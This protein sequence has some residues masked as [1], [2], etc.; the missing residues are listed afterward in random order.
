MIPH[1]INYCWFG[2]E[3]LN[4][5]SKKCIESWKKYLPGWQ[6]KEW[7]EDNFD[8]NFNDYVKEA[9]ERKKW[10]FVSD[11][12]RLVIIEK[13]G[14]IYLDT[15]V[16]LIVNIEGLIEEGPFMGIESIEPHVKVNPGLIIAAEK[17]NE[18]IQ[19]VLETYKGEH[20]TSNTGDSSKYTIV[21][22]TTDVLRKKYSFSNNNSVQDLGVIC[23]YPKDYFCPINYTTGKLDITD[24]TKS[25]H[26]FESSWLTPEQKKR[27]KSIQKINCRY[28]ICVAKI[29]EYFVIKGGAVYDILKKDGV[30]GVLK[31]LGL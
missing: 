5:K 8:I 23:I 26:W 27:Q 30:R 9:Y 3:P 19:S 21:E 20:F 31:R 24:N 15:D 11:V 25:I 1:V 22:R 6:I 2:R 18:V 13:E 7:N 14:G 4:E 29:V 28:P 10:A 12:A 17:H 16:E